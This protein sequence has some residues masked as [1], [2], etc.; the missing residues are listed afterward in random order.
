MRMDTSPITCH[1]LEHFYHINGS[2]FE[3][4]YKETL[5]GYRSWKDLS[6]ADQWLVF[7]ENIGPFLAIDETA[8]SNG[9][10][11]TLVTNRERHGGQRLFSCPSCRN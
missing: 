8:L 7:P 4:Q 6:H 3:K 5:S 2:T 11:Y 10:L 9:D 1:T